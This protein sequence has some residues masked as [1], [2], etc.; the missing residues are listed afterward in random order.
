ML[1][2]LRRH[3]PEYLM[4][5]WA[6]GL[7]MIMACAFGV[8]LFHPASP[9]PGLLPSPLLRRFLMGLAMGGTAIGNIYSPWGK[10]SGAHMNPAV[11]LSLLSLGRV[12][13]RDVPGYLAGQFLGGVGGTAL[14][15]V[16]LRRWIADPSVNYVVTVP[17]EAGVVPA[18]AGEM[19]ISF[20]LMMT[21]LLVLDRPRWA[22]YTGIFAGTLVMLYITFESPISGMSM[23]PARTFGSAWVGHVWTDWWI[24]FLAPPLAMLGAAQLYR[25]LHGQQQACAKMHHVAGVKCIFCDYVMGKSAQG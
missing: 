11:T 18:L 17:G 25:R 19:L 16:V 14:A 13:A 21:I 10:R 4:E 3:W 22:P 15:A 24:Y 6:L 12:S 7:F 1:D 8:L 5:G 9:V 2:T 20:C 23:N